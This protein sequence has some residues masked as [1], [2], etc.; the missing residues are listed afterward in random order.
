VDGGWMMQYARCTCI[1][2]HLPSYA[3]LSVATQ[4]RTFFTNPDPCTHCHARH[5]DPVC[6]Y[7]DSCA[8]SAPTCLAPRPCG[9]V[10]DLWLAL[11]CLLPTPNYVCTDPWPDLWTQL[12]H[13]LPSSMRC[14]HGYV[15][16]LWL[17]VRPW[18]TLTYCGYVCVIWTHLL[19]R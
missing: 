10:C 17:K 4:P 9:L 2:T 18:P 19:P 5:R 11:T 1:H 3:P 7:A 14:A 12:W 16:D 13:A 15:V 6:A 8:I